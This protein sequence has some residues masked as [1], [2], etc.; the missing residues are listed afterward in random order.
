MTTT[1][2]IIRRNASDRG[3]ADHGWL[4][5]WHT[6]SFAS[7]YDPKHMGFRAL[8]VINEDRIAPGRGFGAHPHEDMEI[9]TYIL[10]GALQHR[11]SL[12]TGSVIRPGDAQRMSAGAGIVHSEFNASATEPVHLLQIWIEPDRNGVEPSYA[13]RQFPIAQERNRWHTLVSND[14]R[15]GSLTMNADA[16]FRAGRWGS[17]ARGSIAVARDRHAWVHVARGDVTIGDLRLRDGDAIGVS[18]EA[19]L[20][21]TA[22]ADSELV[23]FDLA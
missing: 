14:G 21:L 18:G 17:G 15:D 1:A 7:Y 23:W 8:R 5:T 22:A 13:Q 9:I 11:D 3:H 19:S 12:G 20:D 16:V 4:D 6:F 2:T 10:D